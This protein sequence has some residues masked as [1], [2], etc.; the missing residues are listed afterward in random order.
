[1]DTPCVVG[2]PGRELDGGPQRIE[3]EGGMLRILLRAFDGPFVVPLADVAAVSDR[4]VAGDVALRREAVVPFAQLQGGPAGANLVLVFRRPTR[5][6]GVR[7]QSGGSLGLSRRRSHSEAGLFVDGMRFAVEDP[8][9]AIAALAGAG[10]RPVPDATHALQQVI[11]TDPSAPGESERR[12]RRSRWVAALLT[13]SFLG[14]VLMLL[15]GGLREDH[16]GLGALVLLVG[17][18]ALAGG[19]CGALWLV[20]RQPWRGAPPA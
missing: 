6:P 5:V 13:M 16:R 19:F 20:F 18:L 9:A 10:I 1:M 15:A 14:L 12:R 2:L 11:G 4:R 8:A 7:V 17:F 3:V